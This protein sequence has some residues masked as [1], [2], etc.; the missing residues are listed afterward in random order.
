[1]QRY[2]RD[3]HSEARARLA[4]AKAQAKADSAKRRGSVLAGRR[5]ETAGL[6]QA[7]QASMDLT[8]KLIERTSMSHPTNPN[9]QIEPEAKRGGFGG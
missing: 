6:I 3:V 4:E 7:L 2:V 5:D 8:T 9:D 1:M